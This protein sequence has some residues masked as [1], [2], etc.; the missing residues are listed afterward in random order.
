MNNN[1]INKI[2]DPAT[3]DLNQ[4]LNYKGL[5]YYRWNSTCKNYRRAL[6]VVAGSL[7]AF[8]LIA[9]LAEMKAKSSIFGADGKGGSIL[10]V[11]TIYKD[12]D[13]A[14]GREFQ[15]MRYLID[16]VEDRMTSNRETEQYLI[17]RGVSVE[18]KSRTDLRKKAPH[19]KY[20]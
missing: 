19:F 12:N 1:S 5:D 8:F 2:V 17:D 15:R 18:G 10:E 13:L 7:L 20:F 16:P 3:K 14:Y 6:P 11:K 4:V 9:P